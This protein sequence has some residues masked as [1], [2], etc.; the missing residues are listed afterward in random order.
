[1]YVQTFSLHFFGNL[2]VSKEKWGAPATSCGL[3]FPMLV[4]FPQLYNDNNRC[5]KGIYQIGTCQGIMLFH[6]PQLTHD[7][8]HLRYSLVDSYEVLCYCTDYL[9]WLLCSFIEP[10]IRFMCCIMSQPVPLNALIST[11]KKFRFLTTEEGEM[12][13]LSPGSLYRTLEC[14]K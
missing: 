5:K 7:S 1:M 8:T 6:G 13:L 10:A 11:S 2:E 14:S 3:E 12:M 9:I 4:T